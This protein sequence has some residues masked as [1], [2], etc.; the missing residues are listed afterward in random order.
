M[1]SILFCLAVFIIL[2][3]C[4]PN[5]STYREPRKAKRSYTGKKS[6]DKWM[7]MKRDDILGN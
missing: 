3:G 1:K 7:D 6:K 2:E 4:K 5:Y